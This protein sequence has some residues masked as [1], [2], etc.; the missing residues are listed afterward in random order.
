V[1]KGDVRMADSVAPELVN[2]TA[3][4]ARLLVVTSGG[5][6]GGGGCGCKSDDVSAIEGMGMDSKR[7]KKTRE[8]FL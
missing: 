6:S 8:S 5:R 4:A 2:L 1:A 3:A 7:G